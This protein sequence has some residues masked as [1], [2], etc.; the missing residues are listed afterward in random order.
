MK[1][2]LCK[3]ETFNGNVFTV[4]ITGFDKQSAISSLLNC[5]EIYWIKK[6]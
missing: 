4:E 2:W 5:K 1:K 3:Y 6:I